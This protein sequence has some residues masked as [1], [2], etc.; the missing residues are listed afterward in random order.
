MGNSAEADTALLPSIVPQANYNRAN[1]TGYHP[2]SCDFSLIHENIADTE[3]TTYLH[4]ETIGNGA[5]IEF[6]KAGKIHGVMDIEPKKITF[7][8]N[9]RDMPPS[10]FDLAL[11]GPEQTE[12]INIS[13]SAV[14]TAPGYFSAEL[15]WTRSVRSPGI[16]SQPIKA[17]YIWCATPVSAN[18]C[19]FWWDLGFDGPVRNP[20][21]VKDIWSKVIQEDID[22]VEGLQKSVDARL[23]ERTTDLL[24]SAD[25]PIAAIRRLLKTMAEA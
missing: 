2:T 8:S 5:R 24:V 3:H 18:S 19:H 10:N 6:R 12:N 25:R 17:I 15:E 9:A 14:F 22:I 13:T 1:I 16:A 11:W 23:D 21:A 20:Q 4:G 7:L